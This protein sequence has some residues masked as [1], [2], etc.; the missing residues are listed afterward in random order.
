MK[1]TAIALCL[2]CAAALTAGAASH[3]ELA[4]RGNT[5]IKVFDKAPVRW[6]PDSLPNFSAADADGI[7]HLVNGRIILKK[8]TVPHYLR[9]VKVNVKVRVASNGDRW[10]KSGSCFIIPKQSAVNLIAQR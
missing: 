2:F 5:T 8:I 4:A 7:I 1:R 6:N 9:N 10:D 3:K